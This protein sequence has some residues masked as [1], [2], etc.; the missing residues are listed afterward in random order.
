MG[1]AFAV[2]YNTGGVAVA[3]RNSATVRALDLPDQLA[4]RAAAAEVL[5]PGVMG[6]RI[7]VIILYLMIGARNEE[8]N[9]QLMAHVGV[10]STVAPVRC[11]WE[12]TSR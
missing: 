11:W 12:G 7:A 10:F 1:T 8:P 9:R 2:H 4:G 6:G 5:Y 3:V